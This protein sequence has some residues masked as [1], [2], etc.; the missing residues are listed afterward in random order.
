MIATAVSGARGR[1]SQLILKAIEADKDFSLAVDVSDLDQNYL[2]TITTPIEPLR[3]PWNILQFAKS[4]DIRWLLVR[5][6]FPN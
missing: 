6:G 5:R 4:V 3:Q 2:K 1:V